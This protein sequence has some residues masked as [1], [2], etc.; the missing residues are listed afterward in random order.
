MAM[1]ISAKLSDFIYEYLRNV[2]KMHS[3]Q[4]IWFN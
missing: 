3:K 4:R 1:Q 2:P